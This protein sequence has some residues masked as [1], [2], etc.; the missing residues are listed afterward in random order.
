MAMTPLAQRLHD[1]TK[2]DLRSFRE[3]NVNWFSNHVGE[4]CVYDGSII[5]IFWQK[6]RLHLELKI[7]EYFE[8]IEREAQ[9]VSHASLRL[10]SVT[11]CIGAVVSYGRQVRKTALDLN[12]RWQS[13]NEP[14]DLG[15][16]HDVDDAYIMRRGARLTKAMGLGSEA[17]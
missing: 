14:I 1:K 17:R 11:Q 8:W 2:A 12:A 13:L 16:W 5:D 15:N 6:Q 3:V 9:M 7:A 4:H 10:D